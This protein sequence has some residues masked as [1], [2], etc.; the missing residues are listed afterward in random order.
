MYHGGAIFEPEVPVSKAAQKAQ[1]DFIE[2]VLGWKRA[3]S[4]SGVET[5]QASL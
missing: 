4:G 2:R 5:A 1:K 3:S